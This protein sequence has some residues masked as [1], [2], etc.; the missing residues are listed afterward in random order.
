[1]CCCSFVTY[2]GPWLYSGPWPSSANLTT[3]SDIDLLALYGFIQVPVLT[4]PIAWINIGPS[5][6]SSRSKKRIQSAPSYVQQVYF[7]VIAQYKSAIQTSLKPSAYVSGG[8]NINPF[9]TFEFQPR[10]NIEGGLAT[11]KQDKH[12]AIKLAVNSGQYKDLTNDI[13]LDNS[14]LYGF[15][16][17]W[18]I[19]FD[20]MQ[21]WWGPTYSDN[22]I[23]SNNA[24]PLPTFTIQRMRAESFQNKWLNWIGPW[25]FTT[26]FSVGDKELPNPRPL[27]WL[28]NLTFRPVDS[29]QFSLSRIAFFAGRTRPLTWPMLGNLLIFQDNGQQGSIYFK[30]KNAEPGKEHAEFTIAWLPQ[31][32]FPIP[33]TFYLHTIFR[34][35]WEISPS[36]HHAI[37]LPYRTS[38]MLGASSVFPAY[39]GY[40]RLY[41][42]SEYLIQYRWWLWNRNN[43]CGNDIIYNMYGSYQYP[44]YYGDKILGSPL[45]GEAKGV[46]LGGIY[47][48]ANGNGTTFLIRFLRLNGYSRHYKFGYPFA[49]QNILWV[50]LGRNV[51]LPKKL[52]QL[53]GQIGYLKSINLIEATGLKSSPSAFLTWSKDF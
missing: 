46:N 13:H 27:I 35:A 17:N 1:M 33:T 39:S 19:G 14:Y 11:E 43:K 41:L 25:S 12:V 37:M 30:G 36:I 38:F 2:S 49:R 8:H 34:D 22:M 21:R 52:G 9:R 7:R 3:K 18:A 10:S 47:T 53:S 28:T 26:S 31:N 50:S 20:K 4:W 15:W 29:L 42:E 24:P 23:L 48:Q 5:L 6:L 45:G 44:Y 32:I 40:L 51:I 16:G